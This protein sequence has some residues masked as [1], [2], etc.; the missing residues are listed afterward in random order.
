MNFNLKVEVFDNTTN[1]WKLMSTVP[2]TSIVVRHMKCY[3]VYRFRVIA[4]ANGCDSPPHW[5]NL[6]QVR[7]SVPEPIPNP[8]TIA[9]LT[10]DKVF[11]CYNQWFIELS[12]ELIGNFRSP[13]LGI[14]LTMSAEVLSLSIISIN[15]IT[16]QANGDK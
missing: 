10:A 2:E 8:L 5:T 13:L 1:S 12:L 11:V 7:A 9:E 4:V 6:V 15:N 16:I 3:L 14:R